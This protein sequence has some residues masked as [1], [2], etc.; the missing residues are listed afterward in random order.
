M[1]VGKSADGGFKTFQLI[2]GDEV[3][4][5]GGIKLIGGNFAEA[6]D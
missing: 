6:E 5:R 2:N 1:G 3:F 4:V